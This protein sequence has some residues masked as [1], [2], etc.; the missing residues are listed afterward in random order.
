MWT[1]LPPQLAADLAPKRAQAAEAAAQR[2]LPTWR[3][4]SLEKPTERS[5]IMFGVKDLSAQAL[6]AFDVES[7]FWQGELGAARRALEGCASWNTDQERQL[8]RTEVSFLPYSFL[9]G[10]WGT[11]WI[12]YLHGHTSTACQYRLPSCRQYFSSYLLG[13]QQGTAS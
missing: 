11:A 13:S 7:K 5:S 6:E 8:A 4:K 12:S 1:S 9:Q 2:L 3:A 10:H